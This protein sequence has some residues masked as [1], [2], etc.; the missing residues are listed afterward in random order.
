MHLIAAV[1][2]IIGCLALTGFA[3]IDTETEETSQIALTLN[4]KHVEDNELEETSPKNHIGWDPRTVEQ[5]N[6]AQIAQKA[7]HFAS[8]PGWISS[9]G[10]QDSPQVYRGRTSSRACRQNRRPYQICLSRV[11]SS[12]PTENQNSNSPQVPSIRKDTK[13]TGQ[14]DETKNTFGGSEPF[15]MNPIDVNQPLISSHVQ[16]R[17]TPLYPLPNLGWYPDTSIQIQPTNSTQ[18]LQYFGVA[19]Q[20]QKFVNETL[21]RVPSGICQKEVP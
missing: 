8:Y 4:E 21:S 2:C 19:P 14:L 17:Q 11:S 20:Y 13:E 9:Q 1:C 16:K 7:E 6:R 3:K 15:D 5:V 12:H 10:K 18:R